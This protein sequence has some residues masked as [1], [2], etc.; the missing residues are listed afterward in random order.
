[1]YL[2]PYKNSDDSDQGTY[3]S[4]RPSDNRAKNI[5][6]CLPGGFSGSG[7]EYEMYKNNC[8]ELMAD[9][10]KDEW[11]KECDLYVSNLDNKQAELFKE[12]INYRQNAYSKFSNR[13]SCHQ[14][15]GIVNGQVDVRGI[16]PTTSGD[17]SYN[18]ITHP[19]SCPP[20]SVKILGTSDSTAEQLMK[21]RYHQTLTNTEFPFSREV[22]APPVFR[23]ERFQS[24]IIQKEMK[25]KH[26]FH[27]E[28]SMKYEKPRVDVANQRREEFQSEMINHK[29]FKES[30]SEWN[31]MRLHAQHYQMESEVQIEN[32]IPKPQPFVITGQKFNPPNDL[33]P[34]KP[35]IPFYPS[36]DP[37]SGEQYPQPPTPFLPSVPDKP[38]V[39]PIPFYPTEKKVVEQKTDITKLVEIKQEKPLPVLIEESDDATPISLLIPDSESGMVHNNQEK[40]IQNILFGSD[41]GSTSCS[42]QKILQM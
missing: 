35:P 3:F 1:M 19:R 8:L 28:Q 27:H 16:N 13:H 37:S 30:Y 42:I 12:M 31:P 9:Q 24:E 20:S 38:E 26:Q 18:K 23:R 36:E 21:Q 22:Q 40:E 25:D 5:K 29:M 15:S 41:C 11:G 17:S 32:N 7:A 39:K 2:S 14:V 33:P 34:N 4:Y 6:T 10:C